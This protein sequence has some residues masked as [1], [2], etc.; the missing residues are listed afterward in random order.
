MKKL[1]TVGVK[2][3]QRAYEPIVVLSGKFPGHDPLEEVS[4]QITNTLPVSR[5]LIELR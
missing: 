5:V 2:G 3:D 4:I 1:Q